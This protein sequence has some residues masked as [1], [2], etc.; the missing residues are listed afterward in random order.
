[1]AWFVYVYRSTEQGGL[2]ITKVADFE[3]AVVAAASSMRPD[4]FRGMTLYAAADGRIDYVSVHEPRALP[5]GVHGISI[6]SEQHVREIIADGD[7][8]GNDRSLDRAALNAKL[9]AP[10]T[11]KG[12]TMFNPFH[13]L[14]V[15]AKEAV[16]RGIAEACL[17]ALPAGEGPPATLAELHQ[18]LT[19]P[20]AIADKPDAEGKRPRK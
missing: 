16:Q 1:M 4:G 19:Q 12:E 15:K 3:T 18:Q 11:S 10:A 20:A 5:D 7:A 14:A 6:Y 8:E 17:E 2:S 9:C 13:W